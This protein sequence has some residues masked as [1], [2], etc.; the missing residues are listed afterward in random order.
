MQFDKGYISR[1]W[2]P[3]ADMK[4]ELED[5]SSHL[6]EEAVERRDMLPLLEKVAQ[7]PSVAIIAEDVESE[8]LAAWW[9]PAPRRLTSRGQ[10]PGFGDR[11]KAMLGDIAILTAGSSSA[12]TRSELENVTSTSLE[13]Q[14]GQGEKENTTIVGGAGRRPTSE[15]RRADS[16][17]DGQTERS[18]T[19]R[20]SATLAS[21]S[22]RAIIRVGVR[23]R[24]HE[25]EEA[26]VEDACTPPALRSKRVSCRAAS[27]ACGHSVSTVAESSRAIEG[28]RRD[29]GRA[30]ESRSA[31][32]R[33]IRQDGAV[34]P[35]KSCSGARIGEHR[36]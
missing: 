2:S 4:C 11:R 36:L 21:S 22:R 16:H 7:S 35:M 24:R 26:R 17:A 31:R 14:D 23:P 18:T 9:S 15:A 8:A 12:R 29:R 32:S 13:V 19:R 6:R 28:R 30:L 3:I 10:G 5:R 1:T 33:R 25:A 20:S 34:L 27:L